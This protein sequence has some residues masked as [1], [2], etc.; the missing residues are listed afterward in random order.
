VAPLDHRRH[1]VFFAFE[2]GF[3]LAVVPVANPTSGPDALGHGAARVSE[4][5][6][7]HPPGHHHSTSNHAAMVAT[8]VPPV[9][10]HANLRT[11]IVRLLDAHDCSGFHV[12]VMGGRDPGDL[13][14]LLRKE[15][16]GRLADEHEHAWV[17]VRAIRRLAAGQVRETWESDFERMLSM[18]ATRGWL[19]SSGTH[20]RGH[21][22][23]APT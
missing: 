7:L 6:A 15:R 8:T 19:N 20:L 1:H 14:A 17:A 22:E 13:D 16:V 9:H 3:D 18:A 2:D 4:P 11:R 5:H 10:V 23:W 21:L 12:A